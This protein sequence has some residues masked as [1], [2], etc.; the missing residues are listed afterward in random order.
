MRLHAADHCACAKADRGSSPPMGGS[1]QNPFSTCRSKAQESRPKIGLPDRK[2]SA[3]L[4]AAV[5]GQ[6]NRRK[7]PSGC[8]AWGGRRYFCEN[9]NRSASA[10]AENRGQPAASRTAP[11]G[12]TARCLAPTDHSTS[13]RGSI[14]CS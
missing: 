2:N 7:R 11:S 12:R 14:E 1:W 3:S 4:R 8:P 13:A 5:H 6:E 10:T 9:E